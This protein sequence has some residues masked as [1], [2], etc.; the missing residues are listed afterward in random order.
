MQRASIAGLFSHNAYIEL[1]CTLCAS[2]SDSRAVGHALLTVSDHDELCVVQFRLCDTL[3]EQPRR[4]REP[5]V[6]HVAAGEHRAARLNGLVG[7]A[8]FALARDPRTGAVGLRARGWD[9]AYMLSQRTLKRA[10]EWALQASSYGAVLGTNHLC[11]EHRYS[12]RIRSSCE[13]C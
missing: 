3:L 6:E 10:V 11:G 4:L 5:L 12:V 7:A 9:A 1:R 2:V 8:R 13:A